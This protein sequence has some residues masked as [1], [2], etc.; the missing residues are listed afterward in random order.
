MEE[1]KDERIRPQT[2]DSWIRFQMNRTIALPIVVVC[3]NRLI[4]RDYEINEFM[5]LHD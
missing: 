4:R 3:K 5:K 1:K 2:D